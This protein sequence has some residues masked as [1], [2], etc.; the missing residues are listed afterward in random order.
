MPE[1]ANPA[2]RETSTP[3]ANVDAAL[4]LVLNL[5]DI[6]V[7][8]SAR[9][10]GMPIAPFAAILQKKFKLADPKKAKPDKAFNA[11]RALILKE[12]AIIHHPQG[13]V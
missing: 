13:H 8:T 3:R 5:G 12:D 2:A 11:L 4:W 10:L 6:E 7:W 9:A 1:A